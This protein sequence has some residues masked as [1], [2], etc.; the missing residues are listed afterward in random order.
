MLLC[1]CS[2]RSQQQMHR[3]R[4]DS[5]FAHSSLGFVT[6]RARENASRWYRVNSN[7]VVS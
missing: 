4:K 2:L 7:V 6:Q 5:G 3:N 1:Y